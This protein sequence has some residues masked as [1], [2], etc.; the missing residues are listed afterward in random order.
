M[1]DWA[2][3]CPSGDPECIGTTINPTIDKDSFEHI[4]PF[5]YVGGGYFRRKGVPKGETA[6]TLHG[7]DAARL[8][9][10]ALLNIE[11][12]CPY[13]Q[14]DELMFQP[15]G[16]HDA[17][18]QGQPKPS[19][20]QLQWVFCY[21]ADLCQSKGQSY[22]Y[23]LQR[24]YGFPSREKMAAQGAGQLVMNTINCA[25]ENPEVMKEV[26]KCYT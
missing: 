20:E 19:G 26:G 4:F 12:P 13:I 24:M 11:K 7:M 23:V 6:E 25:I 21:L 2:I 8:V 3:N 5:D 9:F 15:D 22:G 16:F 1:A 17:I 18:L 14:V 10:D